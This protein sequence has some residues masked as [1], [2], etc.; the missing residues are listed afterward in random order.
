MFRFPRKGLFP[1][2]WTHP[3]LGSTVLT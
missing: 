2:T 1:I 3:Q